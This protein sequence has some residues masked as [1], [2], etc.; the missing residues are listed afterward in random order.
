MLLF[1]GWAGDCFANCGEIEMVC[2][3]LGG[4]DKIAG[5]PCF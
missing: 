3:G 5:W 4:G 2:H 1:M